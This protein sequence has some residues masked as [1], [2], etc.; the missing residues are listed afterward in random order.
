MQQTKIESLVESAVN[1]L[2]GYFVALI[3]QIILFPIF[4]I[5]VPLAT[6][7]WIGLWFTVISF[8]RSYMIR[9]WFNAGIH[10]TIF[11]IVR[12]IGMIYVIKNKY[13]FRYKLLLWACHILD[14]LVCL[15]TLGFCGSAF[16]MYGHRK[17]TKDFIQRIVI[18][19]DKENGNT[20]V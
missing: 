6:N 9:R 13:T 1:V 14:A 12:V 20:K 18:L 17:G 8:V 19:R 10:K 15:L 11:Y 2:I 5:V 3:S 4:G 16:I 7:L